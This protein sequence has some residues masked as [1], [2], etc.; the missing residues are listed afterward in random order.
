VLAAILLSPQIFVRGLNL[1]HYLLCSGLNVCLLNAVSELFLKN[2]KRKF[3]YNANE[4][5]P[6]SVNYVDFYI[7]IRKYSNWIVLS[8][9]FRYSYAGGKFKCAYAE[10]TGCDGHTGFA[11]VGTP[12]QSRVIK[13]NFS[14]VHWNFY[15]YSLKMIQYNKPSLIRLQ[16]VRIEIWKIINAVHRWVYNLK[17]TWHL[18]R[19]MESLVCSDKT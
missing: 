11:P 7:T 8:T 10:E 18:G 17:D 6:S 5:L 2:F 9:Y 15:I 13:G 3:L 4:G 16:L 14:R 12:S 19:H 1:Y